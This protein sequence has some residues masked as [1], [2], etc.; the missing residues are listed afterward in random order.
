VPW[1][2]ELEELRHDAKGEVFEAMYFLYADRIAGEIAH[3]SSSHSKSA[4]TSV[5][6]DMIPT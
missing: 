5:Y 6:S 4:A 1:V 2:S 3:R